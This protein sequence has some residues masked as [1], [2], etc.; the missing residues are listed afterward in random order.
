MQEKEPA[1]FAEFPSS[2]KEEWLAEIAKNLKGQPIESLQSLTYE[3]ITL[4]PFYTREDTTDQL[5]Q[6]TD[7][8][9]GQ[10][11]QN[12]MEAKPNEV[13]LAIASLQQGADAITM[14][15]RGEKSLTF[16]EDIPLEDNKNAAFYFLLDA[17][18][19]K[20]SIRSLY[21]RPFKGGIFLDVLGEWTLTGQ[22]PENAWETLG[23]LLTAFK[24]RKDL[25]T[26]LVNG[27]VF[28][29]AGANAL[30]ELAYT[31]SMAVEYLHQLTERGF[32]A[33]E[34]I[35]KMEIS[36]AAGGEYFIE[37]AKFRAMRF[38]WK[39]IL[40]AYPL[41][42]SEEIFASFSLHVRTTA[43]NK[44]LAD[45]YN[46]MLRT[47]TEALSAVLG[48]VDALTVGPYN[49][50]FAQ[51][52]E[53]AARIARNVSIIL[54]E[55]AHL[56]KTTD[57]GSGAYYIEYLTGQL[58][59]KAWNLFQ[60]TEAQGG[61]MQSFSNRLIQDEI[62]K[63]ALQKIK[64]FEDNHSVLIG[65]NKYEKKEE[66]LEE[67]LQKE[68]E[69]SSGLKTLSARRLAALKEEAKRKK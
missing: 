52:D 24:D 65:V 42:N 11:W 51:N 41:A 31:L 12:R 8:K 26:V 2:G 33:S 4:H 58:A 34:V 63:I 13:Q 45:P 48:G 64:N 16:L 5:L 36:M 23:D 3:G 17:A 50:I 35:S 28:Q 21:S 18:T 44:S 38:L 9:P 20:E 49:E 66:I 6:A 59:E 57:T 27:Q 7:F 29:Q 62:E 54:K 43:W 25:K 55:E 53:F 61:F 40:S 56:D 69:Y 15:L 1:F 22:M 14:D 39:N 37:I 10:G 32:K 46:N 19:D 67:P 60:Q 68:K 30:Q 47:T